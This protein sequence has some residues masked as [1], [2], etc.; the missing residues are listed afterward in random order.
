MNLTRRFP[1]H[2]FSE[3]LPGLKDPHTTFFFEGRR[4][5][6]RAQGDLLARAMHFQ[7]IAWF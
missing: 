3:R 7:G 2:I 5:S 1:N 6:K 4:S